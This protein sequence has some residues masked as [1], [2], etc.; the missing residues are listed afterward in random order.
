M[1]DAEC[2]Y[3]GEEIEFKRFMHGNCPTCNGPYMACH[4]CEWDGKEL[5]CHDWIE[6]D[7]T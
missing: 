2:P 5:W 3:C 1:I 7:E 6:K 4:D